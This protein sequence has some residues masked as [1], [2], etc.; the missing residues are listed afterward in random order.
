MSTSSK[1]WR[2][3][4][5]LIAVNERPRI[6]RLGHAF[7]RQ[8]NLAAQSPRLALLQGSLVRQLPNGFYTRIE[9]QLNEAVESHP[10]IIQ[11]I[12]VRAMLDASRE[13][14]YR[15]V[16]SGAEHLISMLDRQNAW[17]VGATDSAA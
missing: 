9:G 14:M 17:D 7:H 11:A 13:S 6:T 1:R 12:L 15:H 5:G 4:I 2:T 3:S 8:I 10:V 16:L